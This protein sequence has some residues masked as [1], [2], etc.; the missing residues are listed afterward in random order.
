MDI[1]LLPSLYEGL[2][3]VLIEAQANGLPCIASTEVPKVADMGNINF[4]DLNNKEDFIK[5]VLDDKLKRKDC[6]NKIE[7]DGYGIKK[8]AEKLEKIYLDNNRVRVCHIVSGLRGGGVESMIYN[9]CSR[10][11][12]DEIKFYLLYQHEPSKKNV[13]ELKKIG[14][15]LKRIPSKIKHPLKNYLSTYKFLKDNR[16]DV[17]HCHMTLMNFIPLIAARKLN[18]KVRICHS[19]NSDVREKNIF[20]QIIEKYLKH[21]CIKNSSVLL[22]CG[23]DAGK[24][25]YGNNRFLIVTNAIDLSKFAFNSNK[26]RKIK[27]KYNLKD[28]D[29]LIGHIGRFTNQKNHEFIINLFYKLLQKNSNYK[30][31]L[32]G[33]GENKKAIEEKIDKLKISKQVIMPGIVNNPA[34]YYNAMDIFVLPSLWEG[35]PV[36]GIEAQ[37]NGLQCFFSDNIDLRVAITNKVKLLSLDENKWLNEILKCNC[38]YKRNI[39]VSKFSEKGFDIDSEYKRLENIYLNSQR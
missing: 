2:G 1:F 9:Y 15:E 16:I 28:D 5:T 37:A 33:D 18:I 20:K 4:I 36:V 25:L 17:V 3:M 26:R 14:F 7:S 34:D 13:S 22:S 38:T 8:E 12:K 21:L 30:L 11:T 6:I 31:I 32:I 19:H 29:I 27:N 24:Y 39:T 10:M 35:L 23:E